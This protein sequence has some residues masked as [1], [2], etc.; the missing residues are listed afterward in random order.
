[1]IG[2]VILN[3]NGINLLKK[4]L[5]SIINYSL[6][7][8]IYIIDNNSTDGSQLFIKKNYLSVKLI[9]NKINYG[10]AKGYNI[11]LKSINEDILCLINNDVLV[12]ENWLKPIIHSFNSYPEI[13]IAQPII[14]DLNKPNYFNYSGAAGGFIDKFG[15]TYCRGRIFN[16]LEKNSDQ[17]SG[18]SQIFWASGACFFIRKNV[19]D[20]LNGFDSDFFMHQEEIDLCWR[21]FNNNYKVYNI[22]DSTVFHLGE[23]T[24]PES[25]KKLFYNFRN[26]FLMLIKNVPTLD[27]LS[28]IVIRIFLDFLAFLRF[29][30]LGKFSE[31][32]MIIKAYYS[33]S[34]IVYKKIKQRDVFLNTNIYYHKISVAFDYFILKRSK[35]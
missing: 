3:W 18:L 6:N 29:I 22:S 11:G 31:S 24:L 34:K 33:I 21:A 26:S 12:T 17:Y 28:I 8:N 5:P 27:F 35:F 9:Q 15:Y 2:I 4:F 30:F 23:A 1:M 7:A 14:L 10:Y 19:F 13:S 20:S 32:I 25:P 16:Y